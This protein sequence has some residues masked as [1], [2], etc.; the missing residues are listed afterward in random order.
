MADEYERRNEADER[1][2]RDE[3]VEG[4]PRG[5]DPDVHLHTDFGKKRSVSPPTR[6]RRPTA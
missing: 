3:P 6:A 1:E 2:R 5:G 4:A